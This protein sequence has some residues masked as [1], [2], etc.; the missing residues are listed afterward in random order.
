[1]KGDKC[2]YCDEPAIGYEWYRGIKG[3]NVCENH[4]SKELNALKSG[5]KVKHEFGT[6]HKYEVN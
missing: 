2:S 6:F 5:E 3:V 1:M 4:A